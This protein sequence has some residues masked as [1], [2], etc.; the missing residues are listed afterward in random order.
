M[1]DTAGGAT[2]NGI[3]MR[4][5]RIT[6]QID[7]RHGDGPWAEYHTPPEYDVRRDSGTGRAVGQALRAGDDIRKMHEV[8]KKV[9]E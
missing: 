7:Q 5:D 4:V 1:I 6:G 8:A 9:T 2:Q 3:Q